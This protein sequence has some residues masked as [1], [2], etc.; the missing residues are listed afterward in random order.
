MQRRELTEKILEI[1]VRQ[2]VELEIH[3]P[4]DR[5]LFP[6]P[7]RR[8]GPR[9]DEADQAAGYEGGGA[10]W[11][12]GRGNIDAQRDSDARRRRAHAAYGSIDISLLRARH[13]EW[14]G[15]EGADRGGS[16]MASCRPSI[17]TWRS[18]GCRTREAIA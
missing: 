8:R 14:A 11:F 2:G 3:S 18:S 17:S 5:W 13:G 4:A 7:S 9:T 6:G 10:L 15:L 1:K 12:D 16:A